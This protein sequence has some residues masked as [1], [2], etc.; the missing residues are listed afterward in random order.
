MAVQE[1]ITKN[2][3][4]WSLNATFHLIRLV[5]LLM[6]LYMQWRQWREDRQTGYLIAFIAFATLA[7]TE[8][9]I[10]YFYSASAVL[11]FD[12]PINRHP[13]WGDFL[14]SLSLAIFA[15]STPY[16]LMN[17]SQKVQWKSPVLWSVL[18]LLLVLLD[19]SKLEFASPLYDRIAHYQNALLSLYAV[20]F[21]SWALVV[22]AR[23][24]GGRPGQI[25]FSLAFLIISQVLHF[26]YFSGVTLS[27]FPSTTGKESFRPSVILYIWAFCTTIFLP[28]KDIL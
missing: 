3:D 17:G 4:F 11:H 6:V 9:F 1:I 26:G 5:V 28:K 22:V 8:L 21:L 24:P 12:Q 20:G 27:W 10:A 18:F 23:L 16:L 2:F 14:Q 13:L 15:F 25:L 19:L 7:A